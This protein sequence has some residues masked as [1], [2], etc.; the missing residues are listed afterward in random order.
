M[1]RKIVNLHS[2]KPNP[3]RFCDAVYE[4]GKVFLEVKNIKTPTRILWKDL[5]FQMKNFS[6]EVKNGTA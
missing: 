4:N 6:E 1:R 2:E 3:P 5:E